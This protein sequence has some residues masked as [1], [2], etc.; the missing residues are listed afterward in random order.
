MGYAVLPWVVVALRDRGGG[1]RLPARLPVLLLLGS[2]SASAGLATAVAALAVGVRRSDPRRTLVLLGWLLAANAPWLVA[3]VVQSSSATSDPAGAELFATAGEG[4]LPGPLAALSFGGIWN[5]EV[6]PTS[7][8]GWAGL[9][10]TLLL[11]GAA[12]VGLVR[13]VRGRARVA[14]LGGLVV[15]WLVGTGLAVL[16]W[17]APGVLG[18]LAAHVPG[19]GLVRDGSRLLGLSVPSSWCWWPSP[20]TPCST[21]WPTQRP[22]CSWVG[23]WCWCRS[24]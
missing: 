6:V 1:A 15:C 7:R 24:A 3:G 13:V 18:Q 23:C 9:V 20:S 12:V 19:G 4:L 5:A 17:A 16:S 10:M 14:A 8:T 22:A 21:T 2:L 11:V